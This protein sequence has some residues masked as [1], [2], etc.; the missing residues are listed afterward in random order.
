[1]QTIYAFGANVMGD[2]SAIDFETPEFNIYDDVHPTLQN[3]IDYQKIFGSL[4]K[5]QNEITAF[6]DG[7][8]AL[9]G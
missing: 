5:P 3:H 6:I 7:V 2:F 4:L 9:R 1:M 8:K